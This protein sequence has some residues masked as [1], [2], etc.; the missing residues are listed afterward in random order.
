MYNVLQV[1][2]LFAHLTVYLGVGGRRQRIP[3]CLRGGIAWKMHMENKNS[4]KSPK[5]RV[6]RPSGKKW[7]ISCLTTLRKYSVKLDLDASCGWEN[8]EARQAK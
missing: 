7:G 5:R 2:R 6:L 8:G 4:F 1:T 3:W